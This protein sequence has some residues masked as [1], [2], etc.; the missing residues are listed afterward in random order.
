MFAHNLLN[1]D[2]DNND[3]FLVDSLL[4]L[5]KHAK[6]IVLQNVDC[7]LDTRWE[8]LSHIDTLSIKCLQVQIIERLGKLLYGNFTAHKAFRELIVSLNK[9]Q[10]AE[11]K[12]LCVALVGKTLIAWC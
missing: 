2:S 3:T 11:K 1:V 12:C 10:V 6:T 8:C 7:S 4:L 5:N 9:C